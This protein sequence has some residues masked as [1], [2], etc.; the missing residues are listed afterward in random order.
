MVMTHELAVQEETPMIA[1]KSRKAF[2]ISQIFSITD[3][4]LWLHPNESSHVR[5]LKSNDG[6]RE[7]Q[8]FVYEELTT[9]IVF[10]ANNE[11]Y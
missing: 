9:I 3:M 7:L 5:T 1:K 8:K 10:L 6:F 2:H 4:K 11:L